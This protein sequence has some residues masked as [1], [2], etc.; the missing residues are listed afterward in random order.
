M[1]G[2]VSVVAVGA[3]TPV[4]LRAES[5]A[6]AV[7]A[8]ISRLGDHPTL[9]TATGDPL[10]C[11]YDAQL[12][13]T[14]R[15]PVRM[16]EMVLGALR[17]TL[18]KVPGLG[19]P[20]IPLH[21]YLGLPD[22]R[23]GFGKAEADALVT[24]VRKAAV[25]G[26]S[27]IDVDY[28]MAGH[29]SGLRALEV[30]TQAIAQR[31]R[32]FCVVGGVDSYFEMPTLKWLEDNRR[33]ARDGVRGGFSPGE[34]AGM[35]ALMSRSEHGRRRIPALARVRATATGRE[36]RSLASDE[37]ILGEGLTDVVARATHGLR[38]PDEAVDDVYCDINGERHRADEWAFT[39]LRLP[40]VVRDYSG[41]QSA[42]GSW[43]DVGAASGVLGCV[44]AVQAWRRRYARGPRAL[45]WASSTDGFRAATVLER[46]E[47]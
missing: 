17:E 11:A 1:T 15:A 30:A 47:A 7:R 36:P 14:V 29:A 23:P 18:S 24:Q 19:T 46:V 34:A 28:L 40:T 10:R 26:V 45:V 27:R 25:P 20:P 41:Y 4:G 5:A 3:R 31:Q 22:A 38:V 6:A 37:G 13:P 43:G 44:L 39:A 12:A 35:V 9:V 42:V 16:A 21:L 8:S 2:E 33:L 32:E